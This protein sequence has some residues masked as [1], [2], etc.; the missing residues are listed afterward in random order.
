MGLRFYVRS[1]L[2]LPI[3]A[4]VLSKAKS[5]IIVPKVL[6]EPDFVDLSRPCRGGATL[7]QQRIGGNLFVAVR[8]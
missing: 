8:L 5:L 2:E 4:C 1:I 7:R 6:A 3:S